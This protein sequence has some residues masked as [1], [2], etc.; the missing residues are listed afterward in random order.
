MMPGGVIARNPVR[1]TGGG[2]LNEE[3]LLHHDGGGEDVKRFG[4]NIPAGINTMIN[5]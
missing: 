4:G 1:E 3:S 2:G 5:K